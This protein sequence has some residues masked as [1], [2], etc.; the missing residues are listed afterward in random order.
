MQ[1]FLNIKSSLEEKSSDKFKMKNSVK[2]KIEKFETDLEQMR[3]EEYLDTCKSLYENI[4]SIFNN[5][6]LKNFAFTLENILN[7]IGAETPLE[8][9]KPDTREE[10]EEKKTKITKKETYE[11][12]PRI[13]EFY[14]QK[15]IKLNKLDY[16]FLGVIKSLNDRGKTS[17]LHDLYIFLNKTDNERYLLE[18]EAQ[19]RMSKVSPKLSLMKKRGLVTNDKKRNWK[20]TDYVELMKYLSPVPK[21]YADKIFKGNCNWYDIADAV[22][23]GATSKD[24]REI[25]VLAGREKQFKGVCRRYTIEDNNYRK[26]IEA[27]NG[28]PMEV[29]RNDGKRMEIGIDARGNVYHK[30]LIRY[31]EE[32]KNQGKL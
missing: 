20:L 23:A 1:R 4:T 15:G 26:Q 8:T 31:I 30:D 10:V 32:M 13:K 22:D 21:E 18:N 14:Q 9:K 29:T 16:S 27:N 3:R 5:E 11:L 12:S 17:N 19:F 2:E 24:V 7:Q 28:K 6:Q 25:Y